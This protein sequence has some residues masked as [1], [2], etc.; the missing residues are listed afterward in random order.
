MH[1]RIPVKFE[2]DSKQIL[3]FFTRVSGRGFDSIFQL[4][5]DGYLCGQMQFE[6]GLNKWVYSGVEGLY[7]E[8]EPYFERVLTAAYQ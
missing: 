8:M 1:K 7:N 3:G 4:H 6:Y 5:V 2:H